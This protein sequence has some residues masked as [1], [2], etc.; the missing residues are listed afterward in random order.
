MEPSQFNIFLPSDKEDQEILINSLSRTL[1]ELPHD[2]AEAVRSRG[3]LSSDMEQALRGIEVLTDSPEEQLEVAL[4]SFRAEQ[5]NIRDLN[6]VIPLTSK[7]NLKCSYCYQVLHGDFQGESAAEI[8]D[9]K[10]DT[11]DRLVKFVRNELEQTNYEGVRIRWYGGEPLLRLDLI[12]SIGELIKRETEAFG[13]RLSGMV[14][15][16]GVL[17][18]EKAIRLLK[19]FKV[20]RLEISVDGPQHTHDLL[21]ASR[22][23]R[24]TYDEILRSVVNAADHFETIVFR[25]NVH[26]KNAEEINDWLYIVAPT[27]T[28]PNVFLKFKL[29]EGDKTNDLD[30][31]AFAALTLEY[32]YTAKELGLN[33]LQKR[34]ATET[35]PAIRQNYFIVQSDLKVYKCPQNLGS[36]NNVGHIGST[37]ALETNWR[38]AHW[39]GYD[40]ANNSDCSSCAHLPHCNGGCPYN[41]IMH[42]INS[43]ALK[44]YNRKERCCREKLV[45]ELLLPRLV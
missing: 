19:R 40:V 44:V 28:K 21:R 9:W 20:D 32:S 18:S 30:Y 2:V 7:C 14:V 39:T 6:V 8:A 42:T 34:L 37:G 4:Q 12:E 41:E 31:Q 24:S 1:C 15:T 11:I 10:P 26:S 13:R 45:P 22:S 23:G 38:M 16:N 3:S 36:G 5:S 29:V 33:L 17:I 27:I 35:C 43:R 25:V